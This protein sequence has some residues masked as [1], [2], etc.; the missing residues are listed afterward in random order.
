MPALE[1]LNLAKK[2]KD[3]EAVRGISFE[4]NEGEI[5]ALVGPN[6]AGKSTTLK[7]I[8]TILV[9]TSGSVKIFG[10]AAAAEP[11]KVR[12]MISYLP[13]EAGAYRNLAGREYLEF[14]ASIF[15]AD[16]E[17]AREAARRGSELSGLGGRLSEKI[18]TYSKGMT[19]KLLLAR[20]VMT[21]P[22]LAILDEP[23]SGLDILNAFEIRRTIKDL[24]RG[25]MSFLISSHN[26]MEIEFLSD[27]I[28]IVHRGKM[29]AGDSPENLKKRFGTG[30]LE[31]VFV[32]LARREAAG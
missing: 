27:R 13:E 19:R 15:M 11:M 4:I 7:I 14:M 2:Y 28:G 17:S 26:M 3:F 29:L 32:K 6:G 31:D 5:F 16:S 23:T 20:T 8:S 12:R 24:A 21:G 30:D 18:K 9:P 10:A 22:R 1:V 25:G